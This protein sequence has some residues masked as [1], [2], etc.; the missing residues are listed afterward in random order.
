MDGKEAEGLGHRHP[1]SLPLTLGVPILPHLYSGTLL[2]AEEDE[3]ETVL[4]EGNLAFLFVDP[5]R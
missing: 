5:K 1:R 2:L 3:V 4:S